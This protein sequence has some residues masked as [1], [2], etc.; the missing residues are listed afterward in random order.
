LEDD[1]ERLPDALHG[2]KSPGLGKAALGV[3]RDSSLSLPRSLQLS[4]SKRSKLKK[5]LQEWM[6]SRKDPDILGTDTEVF[7]RLPALPLPH[8]SYAALIG[9]TI[10][11]S[12]K[13]RRSAQGIC[14]DIMKKYPWYN[15]ELHA[16]WQV[17]PIFS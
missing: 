15:E 14:K 6:H 4:N 13:R 2:L 12:P 9:D 7:C 8:Q 17:D 1:I 3:R 16:D 5:I 10:L 11:Q